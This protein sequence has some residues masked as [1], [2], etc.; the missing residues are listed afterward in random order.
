MREAT[1]L[2]TRHV[3]EIAAAGLLTSSELVDLEESLKL[4]FLAAK[5]RVGELQKQEF[6]EAYQSVLHPAQ[7]EVPPS[8]DGSAAPSP[9]LCCPKCSSVDLAANKAGF[10]LGKAI[11]GGVLIGG[12][13]LLGGF[14]GSTK[15]D[16]TCMKCG[17]S[18]KA[19]KQ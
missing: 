2:A 12:V 16:I 5:S 14:I 15:V 13:G 6:T 3:R 1:D 10:G 7:G 11:V 9:T 19:G 18:W 8:S 17:Y 4:E